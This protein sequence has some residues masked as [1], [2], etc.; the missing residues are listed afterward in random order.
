MTITVALYHE[1]QRYGG[2][3]EGGWWYIAGYRL[4][5]LRR[6]RG[7]HA[8]VRAWKFCDRYNAGL[9][10]RDLKTKRPR[11]TSVLSSGREVAR[12]NS[13]RPID[14]YPESRPYYC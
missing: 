11:F 3:E 10:G 6:F 2:P 9:R 8:R 12:F 14:H 1:E 7:K 5:N 13:G 4:R